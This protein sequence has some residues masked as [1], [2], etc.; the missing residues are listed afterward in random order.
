MKYLLPCDQ[1]GQKHAVDPSQAGEAIACACGRKL[2]VPSLRGLRALATQE[3]S[4][5]ALR[6]RAVGSD[7][8]R[9]LICAGGLVLVAAGLLVGG[10]GASMRWRIKAPTLIV[11][12]PAEAEAAVQALGAH[13]AWQ[14]WTEYRDQGLGPYMPPPEYVAKRFS[15]FFS[16]ILIVGLAMAVAG[17]ATAGGV[18]LVPAPAEPRRR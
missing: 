18:Y 1:C 15:G 16:T 3:D 14:L 8:T 9:R 17:A 4:A 12:S 5:D 2:E 13:G 11:E 10:Y 7:L 6:R